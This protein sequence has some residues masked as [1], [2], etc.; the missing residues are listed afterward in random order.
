MRRVAVFG[1]AGGGKSTLARRLAEITRL[2]LHS[3]DTIKYKAGGG[4]VPHDE[5]LRLH[6]ELLRGDRW[7]IDGFGCVPSAWERFGAADTLIYVDLP[8]LTH[9]AWVTKRFVKGLVV[10]PE[11]WPE[12]SPMLSSTL[13][14]YRILRLC[15]EKLTP[16]YRQLTAEQAAHKRVHHVKSPR[17]MRA[18]IR[19]AANEYSGHSVR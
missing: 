13:N 15:H 12:N 3:L 9:Y 4:E 19:D 18:F 11:G 7:I 10:T 8:L 5:Y 1:N 16:R 6:S 17:A 14:S 2:P